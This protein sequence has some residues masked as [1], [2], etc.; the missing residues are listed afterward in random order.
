[1]NLSDKHVALMQRKQA[2]KGQL[3]L[4]RRQG[5]EK[6]SELVMIEAE[7]ETLREQL[8]AEAAQKKA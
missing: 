6:E 5:H 3:E 8:E 2:L 4:L 7:L 1:M